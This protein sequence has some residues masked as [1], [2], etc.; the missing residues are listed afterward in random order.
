MSI[1]RKAKWSLRTIALTYLL[2]LLLL[3]LAVVFF[4]TF[5]HGWSVAWGYM[6]TPAAIS[7]TH[8]CSDTRFG[9]A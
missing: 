6:T 9:G 2:L 1:S 7:A 4:K 3:P 8:S 5:Q